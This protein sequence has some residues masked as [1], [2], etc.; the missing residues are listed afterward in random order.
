MSTVDALIINLM[1]AFSLD[2][3]VRTFEKIFLRERIA[4]S[5]MSM[6]LSVIRSRSRSSKLFFLSYSFVIIEASTSFSL[7]IHLR[8]LEFLC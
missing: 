3:F 8:L 7:I 1:S 2:V 5:S 4:T 6:S